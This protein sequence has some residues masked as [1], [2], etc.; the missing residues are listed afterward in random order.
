[1]ILQ[2]VFALFA[3]FAFGVLFNI[4]GRKLVLAGIG[5]GLGW[6]GYVA[7]LSA[8][9]STLFAFFVGTVVASAY[10]EI[11]AKIVRTP[12][13]T[14][15]I[16]GIIPLVPGGGVYYTVLGIIQGNVDNS[17]HS[18][19]QTLSIS[20]VIAIAMFSVSIFSRILEEK[21]P[22]KRI[23]DLMRK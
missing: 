1:M 8:F 18:G 5:G 20:G 11:M 2:S 16:C 9:H 6:F 14:F 13:S 15:I 19:I 4:K 12:V 7:T 23:K 22:E 21:R 3:S 10:S 17:V